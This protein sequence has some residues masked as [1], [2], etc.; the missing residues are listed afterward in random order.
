MIDINL[1]EKRNDPDLDE[2]DETLD[3][4]NEEQADW[5]DETAVLEEY[6][7]TLIDQF[8]AA[9]EGE[10]LAET[11]NEVG[12]WIQ[13][14]LEYG[15]TYE[16]FSPPTMDA[17]DARMVIESILPRKVSLP[18]PEAADDAMPEL[19]AFWQYLKREYNLGNADKVIRYLMSVSN[20]R[21]R[22]LMFDPSRAG[23]AKSF[24][25]AGQQ[26][27]YDMTDEAE[28]GQFI[29]E[30]NRAVLANPDEAPALP[31]LGDS[32]FPPPSRSS[33]GSA[34]DKAKQKK[35]RK[36]AQASR[37]QNRKPKKKKRK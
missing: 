10:K 2:I 19:I 21:F 5:P 6:I 25:M 28:S 13:T 14:F 1:L 16:G 7:D 11:G 31:A 30:Y 34:K 36:M 17:D 37:K 26:A 35:Q 9:P 15:F 4:E 18:T 20:E 29:N 33:G 12:F 8:M 27:G 3:D 22:K 32:F 23:M 24:F